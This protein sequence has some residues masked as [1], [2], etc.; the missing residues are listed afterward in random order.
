MQTVA[1]GFNVQ[2]TGD[3]RLA[4][5][6]PSGF[7]SDGIAKAVSGAML[8]DGLEVIAQYCDESLDL[9]EGLK[10]HL[11]QSA[12]SQEAIDAI[13]QI[14]P[15]NLQLV[16]RL[17]IAIGDKKEEILKVSAGGQGSGVSQDT[18]IKVC[19]LNGCAGSDD[20][21]KRIFFSPEK[22][23]HYATGDGVT[24]LLMSLKDFLIACKEPAN[25][26]IELLSSLPG[27]DLSGLTFNANDD[28][29]YLNFDLCN[30]QN[31]TFLRTRLS[32]SSFRG[33]D[34]R[35]TKMTDVDFRQETV[36][37]DAQFIGDEEIS[38]WP[39][40]IYRTSGEVL[41][42]IDTIGNKSL[43][44]RLM[45]QVIDLLPPEPVGMDFTIWLTN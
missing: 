19:D 32:F 18:A 36:F 30:L 12:Q 15:E 11:C 27:K 20:P 13:T 2:S 16:K 42:A 43:K 41:K 38:I 10:L 37:D 26:Y 8:S 14:T 25:K 9:D 29:L 4:D 3:S 40:Q 44:V 22:G 17:I 39:H 23:L 7:L 45:H 31:T 6:S 34:L 5:K 24:T 21:G 35:G 1:R 33:A 28:F